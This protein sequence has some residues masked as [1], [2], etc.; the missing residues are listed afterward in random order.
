MWLGPASDS[1]QVTCILANI[2]VLGCGT[3][4]GV[5]TQFSAIPARNHSSRDIRNRVG[6]PLNRCNT[7]I[8][9]TLS[10]GEATN[11]KYLSLSC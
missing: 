7:N 11:E 5:G 9:H 4:D 6:G 8:G 2:P 1:L 10:N 3:I